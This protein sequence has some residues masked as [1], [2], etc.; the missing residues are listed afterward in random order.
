MLY[1]YT[2]YAA[3]LTPVILAAFYW[4]RATAPAAVASIFT[5]TV[6]TIAWDTTFIHSHLPPALASR[7]AILPALLASLL[8]L[9]AVSLA[10]IPP[11]EAQLE[12]LG[13][14]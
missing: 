9:V 4:R 1:A 6:V 10:T 5:G 14:Q 11:S 13:S 8:C 2:V 3:A 12:A 7:D